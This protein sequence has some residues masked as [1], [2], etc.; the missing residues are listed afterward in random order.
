MIHQLLSLKAG[1]AR[2]TAAM[3]LVFAATGAYAAALTEKEAL[4]KLDKTVWSDGLY[5]SWTKPACLSLVVEEKQ[6]KYF[7]VAIMEKHGSGCP[8][9]PATSPVVDRY[10]VYREK[11]QILWYEP[12]E[13]EYQSYAAVK[14][15]RKG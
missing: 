11:D 2:I 15:A 5:K 10:R 8:G 1:R 7:D 9:D 12:A 3:L 4:D 13:G 6:A 14:K